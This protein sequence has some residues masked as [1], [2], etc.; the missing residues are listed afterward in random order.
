[1]ITVILFI[2]FLYIL[3]DKVDTFIKA[4]NCIYMFL[5]AAK[6]ASIEIGART[7]TYVKD[8]AISSMRASFITALRISHFVIGTSPRINSSSEFRK[9]SHPSTTITGMTKAFELS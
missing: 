8:Y 3:I 2:E 6:A 5:G 4:L 1:M 9:M 7:S